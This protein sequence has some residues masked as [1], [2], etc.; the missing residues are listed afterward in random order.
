[1]AYST[2]N[3][4]DLLE[5]WNGRKIIPLEPQLSP[6]GLS[7]TLVGLIST[8]MGLSEAASNLPAYLAM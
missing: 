4:P 3:C 8:K 1:M 7:Q 5:Q 2:E 6:L